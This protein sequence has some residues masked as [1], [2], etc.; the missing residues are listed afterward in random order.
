MRYLS[1]QLQLEW[2]SNYIYGNPLSLS[3]C[4]WL[5][6]QPKRWIRGRLDRI[7]ICFQ[8]SDGSI[9]YGDSLRGVILLICDHTDREIQFHGFS[10][11]LSYFTG[12]HTVGKRAGVDGN[13]ASFWLWTLQLKMDLEQIC[14]CYL[15]FI[16]LHPDTWAKGA[17]QCLRNHINS[18]PV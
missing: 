16:I 1:E 17:F 6:W 13:S 12:P 5:L 14:V 11:G 18:E 2:L 4:I 3:R 8:V 9:N 15:G 7:P 10:L